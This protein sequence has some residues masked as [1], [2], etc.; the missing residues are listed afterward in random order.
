MENEGKYIVPNIPLMN[1]H[2]SE[3]RRSSLISAEQYA[4]ERYEDLKAALEFQSRKPS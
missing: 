1:V 2:F 4:E 3:N